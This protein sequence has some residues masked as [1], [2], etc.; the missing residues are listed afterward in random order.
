LKLRNEAPIQI[1]ADTP[2]QNHSTKLASDSFKQAKMG[3]P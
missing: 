3:R 1:T 2:S